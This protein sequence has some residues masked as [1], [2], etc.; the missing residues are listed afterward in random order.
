LYCRYVLYFNYYK[1]IRMHIVT[2]Q[3][4]IQI[5]YRPSALFIVTAA[6]FASYISDMTDLWLSQ[7]RE[8]LRWPPDERKR[9]QAWQIQ[10]QKL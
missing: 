4:C 6:K 1:H 2:L 8:Y 3:I 9:G 5:F 7:F 10:L